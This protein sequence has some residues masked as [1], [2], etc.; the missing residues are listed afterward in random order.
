M[1]LPELIAGSLE[2]YEQK[3]MQLGEQPERL[4]AL[5]AKVKECRQNSPLFD[6]ARFAR[7]LEAA[8]RAMWDRHTLGE[9]PAAFSV[10]TRVPHGVGGPANRPSMRPRSGGPTMSGPVGAS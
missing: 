4:A 6:A 10:E 1:R 7:R 2:E 5:K 8:Y 9:P 3:A